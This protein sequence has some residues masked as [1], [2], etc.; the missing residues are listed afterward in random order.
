MEQDKKKRKASKP[1]G[2]EFYLARLKAC[3][4]AKFI[5]LSLVAGDAPRK[6]NCLTDIEVECRECGH[7]WNTS[8]QRLM[9]VKSGCPRCY[10]IKRF[11]TDEPKS[12][13][14]EKLDPA[15]VDS[16]VVG[17]MSSFRSRGV[18][19]ANRKTIKR[20]ISRIASVKIPMA[21]IQK[22]MIRLWK[23]EICMIDGITKETIYF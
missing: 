6:V 7:H 18:N 2:E 23:R 17:A 21:D 20:E 4:R 12:P 14:K 15:Y 22:S 8:Y 9:V 19:W 10:K 3:R 5:G 1:R 13:P 11:G 16:M